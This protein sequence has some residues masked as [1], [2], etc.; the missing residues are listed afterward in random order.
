VGAGIQVRFGRVQSA[1]MAVAL[2]SVLG[3]PAYRAAARRIGDSFVLA[4]GAAAA[5]DHLEKLA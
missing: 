3:D 1:E 2:R 5:A 4:G